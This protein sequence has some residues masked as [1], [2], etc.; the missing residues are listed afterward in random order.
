MRKEKTITIDGSFKKKFYNKIE[1]VI[2]ESVRYNLVHEDEE[3]D[4]LPSEGGEESIEPTDNQQQPPTG[5]LGDEPTPPP[6]PED[7]PLVDNTPSP[8][9]PEE[10]S[11]DE[12]QNEI[13]KHNID[14]MKAIHAQFEE[15]NN[16]YKSLNNKVESLNSEVEE[17]KEPT[18]GEKLMAKKYVSHPYYYNLNDVWNG[19]WFNEKYHTKDDDD[20]SVENDKPR[21]HG[22]GI[23]EL[24]DGTFIADFDDLIKHSKKDVNDSFNVY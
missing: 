14:A 23:T 21:N 10:P 9:E 17:V 7:N 1:H 19:N 24:P 16:M 22:G 2:G 13:I 11:V 15:L 3:Y 18:S 6:S 4:E 5:G 20:N 8:V 12:I